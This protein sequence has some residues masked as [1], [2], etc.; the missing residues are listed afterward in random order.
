VPPPSKKRQPCATGNSSPFNFETA[1]SPSP[2]PSASLPGHGLAESR[3]FPER[4]IHTRGTGIPDTSPPT[5]RSYL[6][7]GTQRQPGEGTLE[8][9]HAQPCA[10]ADALPLANQISIEMLPATVMS[11]PDIES[12]LIFEDAKKPLPEVVIIRTFDTSCQ[13]ELTPFGELALDTKP[14]DELE[15]FFTAVEGPGPSSSYSS[16]FRDS[17]GYSPMSLCSSPNLSLLHTPTTPGTDMEEDL[18]LGQG[19]RKGWDDEM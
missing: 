8:E 11:H 18:N 15:N 4:F 13:E 9:V 7:G 16:P 5:T 17:H 2:S 6:S 1:P 12:S 3:T 19:D 14:P 10:S